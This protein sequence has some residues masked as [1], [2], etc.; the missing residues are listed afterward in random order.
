MGSTETSWRARPVATVLVKAAILLAPVALGTAAGLLLAHAVPP[1]AGTAARVAWSLLVLG[2]ST[3][4]LLGAER[5]MRRLA[6]LTLLMRL[7]LVFPDQAP[8]RFGV[9]MKAIRPSRRSSEGT[10]S[11]PRTAWR[12]SPRC[13]R[14]TGAPAATPSGWRRTRR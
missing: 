14:T 12:C 11:R 13:W 8:K 6:P 5:V 7:S 4:V 10:R 9:A 2:T 3:L 1:P